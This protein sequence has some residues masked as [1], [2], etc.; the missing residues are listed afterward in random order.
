[1]LQKAASPPQR[2]LTAFRACHNARVYASS[3]PSRKTEMRDRSRTVQDGPGSNVALLGRTV[4]SHTVPGQ[5]WWRRATVRDQ[6]SPSTLLRRHSLALP[7]RAVRSP[8]PSLCTEKDCQGPVW[9]IA[10]DWWFRS[11]RH[12]VLPVPMLAQHQE[13]IQVQSGCKQETTSQK[14]R[15]GENS[16]PCCALPPLPARDDAQKFPS[17]VCYDTPRRELLSHH[18]RGLWQHLPRLYQR[19][20]RD[21]AGAAAGGETDKDSHKVV[22]LV[23]VSTR[24]H[25]LLVSVGVHFV[26]MTL[27]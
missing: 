10:R 21:S 13:R 27:E 24:H 16:T 22:R 7:Q 11:Y 17:A 6:G 15:N 12:G 3:L 1:M 19:I 9:R 14:Q 25:A 4:A 20:T 26:S 5:A 8:M 23:R 18:S 2:G